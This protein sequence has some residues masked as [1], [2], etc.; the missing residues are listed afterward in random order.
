MTFSTFI[1]FTPFRE[2]SRIC[3][4]KGYTPTHAKIPLNTSFMDLLCARKV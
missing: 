1:S 2:L 3:T 4:K